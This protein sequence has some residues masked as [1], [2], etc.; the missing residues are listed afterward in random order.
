MSNFNTIKIARGDIKK[1]KKINFGELFFDNKTKTLYIGDIDDTDKLYWLKIIKNEEVP[2]FLKGFI[3]GVADGISIKNIN[4]WAENNQFAAK[5]PKKAMK[6][7]EKD[8]VS[9][10]W[11]RIATIVK[12]NAP[13]AEGSFQ[14]QIKSE[15]QSEYDSAESVTAYFQ[16][17][18]GDSN[19]PGGIVT[20]CP[21]YEGNLKSLRIVTDSNNGN[22]KYI[23]ALFVKPDLKLSVYVQSYFNNVYINEDFSPSTG[24]VYPGI[25]FLDV[26]A[27]VVSTSDSQNNNNIALQMLIKMF[28]NGYVQWPGMATPDTLFN[29]QGYRWVEVD[30]EGAFFRAKGSGALPFNS[31]TQPWA[32]V[33]VKGKLIFDAGNKIISSEGVFTHRDLSSQRSWR[34]GSYWTSQEL[35]FKLSRGLSAANVATEVRPK[36]KTIIIWKLEKI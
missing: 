5:T 27:G 17:P 28:E 20:I 32:L 13:S 18:Y 22:K 24:T 26:K 12:G 1:K 11:I 29:I 14:L 25:A 16:V 35:D 21:K 15:K 10:S 8:I 2:D 23:E 36:N 34:Q 31:P 4:I 30:Y 19:A 33:D 7:E 9:N 6:S 3:A